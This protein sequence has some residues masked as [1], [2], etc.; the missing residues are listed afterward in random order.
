M[1]GGVLLNMDKGVP[2]D[3]VMRPVKRADKIFL[4]L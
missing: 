3:M 2:V 4:N 1:N